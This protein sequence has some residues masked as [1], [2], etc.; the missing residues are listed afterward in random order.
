M[1]PWR[2]TVPPFAAYLADG[3]YAGQLETWTRGLRKWGKVRIEMVRRP[4]EQTGFSVLPWRWRVER[5]LAWLGR[6][7]RLKGDYER[8]PQT[9][10][11]LIHVALSHLMTR[12]RAAS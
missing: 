3:A 10:E 11:S 1:V 7:W 4:K 12:R 9:T 6:W 8:L 5:M 2:H